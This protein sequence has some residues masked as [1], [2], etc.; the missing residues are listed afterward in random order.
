MKDDD[1]DRDV[2][3]YFFVVPG[4][5]CKYVLTEWLPYYGTQFCERFGTAWSH[6]AVFE[7]QQTSLNYFKAVR[8]AF[9]LIAMT[10]ATS[11]GAEQRILSGFR[12]NPEWAPSEYDWEQT[13]VNLT[14]RILNLD[15]HSFIASNNVDSRNKKIESL[16]AG[17]AW[18][19]P[20]SIVP[21]GIDPTGRL[22]ARNAAPS[23]CFATVSLEAGRLSLAGLSLNEAAQAFTEHNRIILDEVRRCLWAE[24]KQNAE[25]F[26]RGEALMRQPGLLSV[27]EM[28]SLLKTYRWKQ[29]PTASPLTES[30]SPEQALGQALRLL[31]H[32][33]TGGVFECG[34]DKVTEAIAP[35][36]NSLKAQPYLE[37]T[38]QALNA[39]LH[40]IM[41]DAN[42]ANLQPIEDLP[43]DLFDGRPKMGRQLLR[44]AKNRARRGNGSSARHLLFLSTRGS[45]GFPSGVE[46][47]KLWKKLSAPMR[48]T[49]G[50]TTTRLWLFRK[51][52]EVAIRFTNPAAD[53]RWRDFLERHSDNPRFGGLPLTRQQLRTTIA[54]LQGADGTFDFRMLRA[55]MGHSSERTTFEYMSEAGVR[56]VLNGQIQDFLNY[57]EANAV[58]GID[59]AALHLGVSE[60]NLARR[61]QLGL[62][63][64]LGFANPQNAGG[65]EANAGSPYLLTD[66]AK[67]FSVSNESLLALELADRALKSQ[68]E[69]LI[70]TNPIRFIRR[71]L[72]HAAIISGYR[73]IL[74]SGGYRVK[75][76]KMR[77]RVD[78]ELDAGSLTLPILW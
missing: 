24:L 28:D 53:W 77:E 6:E 63:N 16:R 48:D 29:N 1:N 56:A 40:L 62:E 20:S 41:I 75:L 7:S 42:G 73:Q 36:I 39:A 25:T 72:S 69:R 54:N 44:T 19:W 47:I 49:S 10:G 60:E 13:L 70:A 14:A 15:D 51:P 45:N 26:A 55:I 50:P 4:H 61:Q 65:D 38:P 21:S 8:R 35:I 3:T 5:R 58:V 32:R 57:W 76:R 67:T 71:W 2:A 31:A 66:D 27:R 17:L 78:R 34:Y 9:L 74:E 22:E 33:A 59:D 46:I 12:D 23:K 52:G 18:L 64:G 30:A 37:A 43:Y 11:N 68:M